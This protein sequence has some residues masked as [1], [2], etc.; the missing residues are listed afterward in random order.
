MSLFRFLLMLSLSPSISLH[1]LILTHYQELRRGATNTAKLL[2]PIENKVTYS[3][4]VW[5][6]R[7]DNGLVEECLKTFQE[8]HLLWTEMTSQASVTETPISSTNTTVYIVIDGTWGEAKTIYRK[9]P[10]LLRR[11]PRISLNLDRPSTYCLRSNYGYIKKFS[12]KSTAAGSNLLCTAEVRSIFYY[13]SL[14]IT[15]SVIIISCRPKLNNTV[16]HLLS[17]RLVQHC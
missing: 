14:S 16:L 5:R 17:C 6:G 3:T 10:A 13:L 7:D 9:G 2:K 15:I 8:P 11:L 1:I 12:S 4:L